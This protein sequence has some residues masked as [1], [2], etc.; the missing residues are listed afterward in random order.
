[1]KP[2]YDKLIKYLSKM[3]MTSEGAIKIL[4]RSMSSIAILFGSDFHNG[5]IYSLC[6]PNPEREDGLQI[7]QTKHQKALW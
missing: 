4:G 2:D 7:S 6:S 1:M 5:S 3:N